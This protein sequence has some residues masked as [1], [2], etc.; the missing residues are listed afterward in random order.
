M[1]VRRTSIFL[2]DQDRR[3]ITTLCAR[4]GL[5]TASDAIRFASVRSLPGL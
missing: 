3:A 2:E 1:P 4:Y 5:A